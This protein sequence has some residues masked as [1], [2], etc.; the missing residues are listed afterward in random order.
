MNVWDYLKQSFDIF[1]H[2]SR[3]FSVP[4]FADS[5]QIAA[6]VCE[7]HEHWHL[8]ILLRLL[9]LRVKRF[10]CALPVQMRVAF[11]YSADL[12]L[13]HR[14][15]HIRLGPLG[16]HLGG[17]GRNDTEKRAKSQMIK[18]ALLIIS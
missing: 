14:R 10:R 2:H 18:L 8:S 9:V 5:A 13:P 4:H 16:A 15:C 1:V 17:G 12:R 3:A 7:I 11:E 6:L